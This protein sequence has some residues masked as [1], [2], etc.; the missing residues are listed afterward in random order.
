MI[1]AYGTLERDHIWEGEV[2]LSGDVV[3]PAGRTL[4]IRPGTRVRCAPR[5]RWSCAVFRSAPE[6]WPIEA[7]EREACDL[8][9]LGAL[10][11]RDAVIEG[12]R[13]GG[14]T[15]LGRAR[16]ELSGL[17]LLAGAAAAVQAFD[18][19]RVELDGCELGGE[20]GVWAFGRASVSARGGRIAGARVGLLACE[21]AR[22]R[23]SGAELS[24]GEQAL[25]ADG[26]ALVRARGCRLLGPVVERQQG[27]I[28]HA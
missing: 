28:K 25:L 10:L 21:G 7:S 4:A 6:G 11:A 18:A 5:P 27:W 15:A 8:V 26:W 1:E 22:A 3:V 13:W 19:A 17:K 12:E 16:V 20:I 2:L 24:G 9:V 23:L 14:I